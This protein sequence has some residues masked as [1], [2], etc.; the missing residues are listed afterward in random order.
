MLQGFRVGGRFRDVRVYSHKV[1]GLEALFE[2]PRVI[3][4][5]FGDG[6]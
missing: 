6:S 2:A 1:W 4:Y 3:V 5:M